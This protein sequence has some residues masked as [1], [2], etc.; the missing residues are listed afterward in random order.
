MGGPGIAPREPRLKWVYRHRCVYNGRE[1]FQQMEFIEP[2]PTTK[3]QLCGELY[4]I[5]DAYDNRVYFSKISDPDVWGWTR[6]EP[7]N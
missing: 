6:Y 2:I 1:T 4:T 5:E 7:K 3:C